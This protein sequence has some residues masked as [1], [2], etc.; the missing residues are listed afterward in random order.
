V[1]DV[2]SYT[3]GHH[4]WKIGMEESLDKDVQVTLLNNYGVFGFNG[5]AN[6]TNNPLGDF[7]IGSPNSFTQDAPVAPA[8]N[9][10]YTAFFAQDDYRVHP[11]LTL[12][13]GVR[14][15]L[16][17]SPKDPGDRQSTYIPGVQSTVNPRAPLGLLFPGDTY[18]G[19]TVPRGIVPLRKNH[20]SPRLGIAWDPFG[21]G[22]HPFALAQESSSAAH[23]GMNGTPLRTLNHSQ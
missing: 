5:S 12:N 18:P 8:T 15:D 10:W 19:G 7:V 14:Y 16:Q 3:N 22:R 13:L 4:S 1:R 23:P 20:F 6:L 21:D 11:R 2:A 9:S 17:T